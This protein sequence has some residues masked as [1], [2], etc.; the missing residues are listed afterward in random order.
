MYASSNDSVHREQWTILKDRFSLCDQSYLIGDFNNII[1]IG[2]NLGVR[3]D[4]E[5]NEECIGYLSLDP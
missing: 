2:E 3:K 4:F 1:S 5:V